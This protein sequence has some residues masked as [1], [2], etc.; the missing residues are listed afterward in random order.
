MQEEPTPTWRKPPSLVRLAIWW[1]QH[2][3]LNSYSDSS[4][5]ALMPP[6]DTAAPLSTDAGL[7]N[8]SS[9]VTIVVANKVGGRSHSIP[10]GHPASLPLPQQQTPVY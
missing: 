10:F 2:A 8:L 9:V 4:R 6:T 5:A 7:L 1:L 3:L